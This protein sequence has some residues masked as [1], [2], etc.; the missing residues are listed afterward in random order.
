MSP[1]DLKGDL[2]YTE[3]AK[4]GG[5]NIAPDVFE[6]LESLKNLHDHNRPIPHV[7]KISFIKGNAL[8]TIPRFLEQRPELLISLLYLDFDV[9]EP[10]KIALESLL[11]L[12]VKGGVIAFDELNHPGY[13]GETSALKDVMAL[14]KLKRSPLDPYISWYIKD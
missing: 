3:V 13:P 7:Q 6:T 11:P 10:T 2:V 8:N 4:E 14:P 12:V 1:E 9:Y 5:L